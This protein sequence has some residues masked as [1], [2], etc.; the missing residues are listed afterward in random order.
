MQ[1]IVLFLFLV[2]CLYF[3]CLTNRP[4]VLKL[5]NLKS[6]CV[7]NKSIIYL[8]QNYSL[9]LRAACINYFSSCLRL[10]FEGGLYL[11]A[12]SIRE[13]TVIEVGSQKWLTLT[14]WAVLVPL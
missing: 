7:L 12:A 8:Y 3:L 4:P 1:N 2:C 13:N 6:K 9:Y 11:K 14:I 10:V 5:K